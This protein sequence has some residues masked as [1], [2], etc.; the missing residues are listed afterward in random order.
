MHRS[1]AVAAAASAALSSCFFIVEDHGPSMPQPRS[2]AREPRVASSTEPQAAPAPRE[3]SAPRQDARDV[4][5]FRATERTLANGLKVIVV[6]TGMPDL[7]SLQIPV[8]TG[9]RNE[10][11]PGKTGF[12][13]FFEHMMFAGSAE[14][15]Q[16]KRE[17][18][19]TRA[20]AR[21]NAYTTDDYTNYHMTFAKEDL[22]TILRIEADRF[23]NLAYTEERFRT[24]ARAVLGEYNKN[25]AN[26]ISKLE[27]VL[28]DSAFTTH[29]YKHTTMGFLADIEAMPDQIEY[30]RLFFERWY[31][32]EYTTLIVAGDVDPAR[33]LPM[34]EKYWGSW[35]RGSY[36]VD[37]PREPEPT[38]PVY[39]HVPW[40]AK[41]L[42]VVTVSFHGPAFSETEKDACALDL[43]M[44][45]WFGR[46]S[47]L[48]Q[49]LVVTE[50]KLNALS[51]WPAMDQD[52]G[53]ATVYAELIDAQ[54][55]L[56][57][58]D[59]ILRTIAR[60]TSER[61]AD[62]ELADA[63]SNA[64]YGFS[65][66][67]DNTEAIAGALARFVRFR[68]SYDTLNHLFHLYDSVTPDDAL[69]AAQRYFRDERM[70]VT[71][72]SHEAL[73]PAVG[74]LPRLSSFVPAAPGAE[75]GEF[76]LVLQRGP[77][78]EL[79]FKFQFLAGS[80]HD[81]AGKEGLARVTA[82]MIAD[83]GSTKLRYEE[84]EE[85]LFPIAGAFSERV[86]RELTTFSGSIHADNLEVWAETVLPQLLS[87]GWR[88]EDFARVKQSL[89]NDL[90]QALRTNNDEELGKEVLQAALFAGTPYGHPSQGT[91]AGL[92]SITLDDARQFAREHYTRAGLVVGASGDV[93]DAFLARLRRAFAA[94]PEGSPAAIE[95][96]VAH[97]PQGIEVDIVQKETRAT[98]ISIGHPLDVVRGHPDFVALWLAR[99]WLGEHRSSMSHL[100]Q[101]IREVRGM[102][103]GDYA[104][105]E[106][107]R[108]GM[109]QF[110][111][112][113][114]DA[115]RAQLFEIWIRPVKPEHA[116]HAI[117]IALHELAKLIESGLSQEDFD[118]TREYLAKNVY[119]MT[120]SQ[121]QRLGHALDSRFYGTPDYV[122][123]IRSGLA[124]LTREQ[125]NAAIRRHLSA[126][127]VRVVCITK[128][129][130]GL[131]EALVS[132]A[133]S[134]MT[135]EAPKP[136]ELTD[137]DLVIG[138]KKLAIDPARVRVIPVEQVFAR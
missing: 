10:V 1:I 4:L 59:E 25:S 29:T 39:A 45:L 36:T 101:R 7:V 49:R 73:A 22:E 56:Y 61:V 110:F 99:A 6:P 136:K 119:L 109:F 102:N 17:A 132:D 37:V 125:V 38:A 69:A 86:D 123:Y 78:R 71:T 127:N 105:V 32:P 23:Q 133:P 33:V 21:V 55:A 16:E 43:T 28:R 72:L 42:P 104:Y 124:S 68:R 30:A 47:D 88:E 40:P 54:D 35:Q 90:V 97:R 95:R 70:V 31:R 67:L 13:H 130:E 126:E 51:Y 87:P 19:L 75:A 15:P 116:H 62:G 64:R 98:A 14:Y 120:A 82:A 57:V 84:I 92:D 60:S 9:S 117:R 134:S 129:A 5:P 83:A 26:P 121:S 115:R 77:S 103:Y 48:Y 107:F 114:G 122:E 106:A 111:P 79:V 63:K 81:P 135:Y 96:P 24:E 12:A 76:P 131:R 44:E 137:E 138:A 91:V 108:G 100:Y 41:T 11:E 89:G 34:V 8:Q 113:P 74:A 46:T 112:G 50:Q 80:A 3:A 85:R 93:P 118:S 20:G 2:T 53:L 18:I 52:P 58:R 65:R 27:E 94:L 66:A 128:D